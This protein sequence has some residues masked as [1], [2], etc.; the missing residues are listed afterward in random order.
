M[1]GPMDI[2]LAKAN[3]ISRN[4]SSEPQKVTTGADSSTRNSQEEKLRDRTFRIQDGK[5]REREPKPQRG[6]RINE[7]FLWKSKEWRD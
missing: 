7:K 1:V 6:N 3:D 5:N 4:I 2:V